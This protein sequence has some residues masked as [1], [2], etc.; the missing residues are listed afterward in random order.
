MARRR[1]ISCIRTLRSCRLGF[2]READQLRFIRENINI[3][4]SGITHKLRKQGADG[5]SPQQEEG[6]SDTIKNTTCAEVGFTIMIGFAGGSNRWQGV[7]WSG[8]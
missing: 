7:R 6:D 2:R 1:I 4:A 8:L 5:K 3:T